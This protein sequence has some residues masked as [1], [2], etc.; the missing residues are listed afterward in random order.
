MAHVRALVVWNS[1]V[2][3]VQ[4]H[5]PRDNATFWILPGGGSEKDETL[6]DAARREVQEE[7]GVE[8]RVLRQVPVASERGYY[9]FVAEVSGIFDVV[10]EVEACESES[11]T[12]GAAWHPVTEDEPLGPLRRDYWNELAPL[13]RE[14]LRAMSS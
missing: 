4:H 9:L 12:I 10:P 13:I 3:L 6:E 14:R 1:Q 7:T 2:L 11:H 5:D 8:V